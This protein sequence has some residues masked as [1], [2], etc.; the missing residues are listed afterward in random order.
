MIKY[1]LV[2]VMKKFFYPKETV[3]DLLTDK[4]TIEINKNQVKDF[5]SSIPAS[6]HTHTK[7]EITDFPTSITPSKHTHTKSEISD[8]PSTM[9]PSS[10]NHG[11]LNNQ[12]LLNSDT[13]GADVKK[14]VVT[15]STQNLK[16]INKIPFSNLDVSKANITGLGIPASDTNTTYSAGTGLKLNGTAFN[17]FEAPAEEIRHTITEDCDFS[18]INKTGL[19]VNAKVAQNIINELID[20]RLGELFTA[21]GDINTKYLSSSDMQAGRFTNNSFIRFYRIGKVCIANYHLKGNNSFSKGSSYY[22]CNFPE[23]FIPNS[24]TYLSTWVNATSAGQLNVET[25]SSGVYQAKIYIATA[26]TSN[27]IIGQ[28]IYF[29]Q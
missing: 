17:V 7:S 8:F 21:T 15:D 5:P 25:T 18:N 11:N 2:R 14:V 24:T 1:Q 22:V 16:T 28:L 12:G 26:N 27:N 29:T 3:D 23:G 10:H 4:E 13:T 20:A 19:P 9:T 6:A